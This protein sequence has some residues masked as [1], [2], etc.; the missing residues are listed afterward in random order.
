MGWHT[1]R[2][3]LSGNHRAVRHWWHSR[4]R[5]L[6][7]RVS[8][9]SWAIYCSSPAASSSDDPVNSVPE[10]GCFPAFGHQLFSRHLAGQRFLLHLILLAAC[11]GLL[12]IKSGSPAPLLHPR[13]RR[14]R[15]PCDVHV[16]CSTSTDI[17]PSV[18]RFDCRGCWP[19]S[20]DL[21]GIH[22]AWHIGQRLPCHLW[23]RYWTSLHAGRTARCGHLVDTC[24]SHAV[25]TLFY[26]PSRRNHWYLDDGRCL[27]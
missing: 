4:H 12:S 13:T 14:G 18:P 10:E 6:R 1:V 17:L 27:H 9:G 25:T 26:A 2:M 3:E 11:G 24:P 8:L 16:Q 23:R 5:L 22:S 15:L 20:V 7:T 19:C 21:R